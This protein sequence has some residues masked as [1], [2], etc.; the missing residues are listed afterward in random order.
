MASTNKIDISIF[1]IFTKAIA[2]SGNLVI[3]AEN[4]SQLLV[5]VLEIKGCTIFVL[6]QE[7]NELEILATFGLSTEYMSKGPVLSTSSIAENIQGTS[8]IIK[9]IDKTDKLQ[10]P[11]NARTEGIG[12]IVSIP[13]VFAHKQ[14][15]VLRLYHHM[16]W[17]IS[18]DDLESLTILAEMTGLAMTYTETRYVFDSLK[19]IVNSVK[20]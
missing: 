11:D 10:Y 15:G 12:A 1:K 20:L 5:G 6:N 19:E 18:D 4:L 7:L 9:D 13:I 14:L 3:M 16:P 2:E 17:D 8:I